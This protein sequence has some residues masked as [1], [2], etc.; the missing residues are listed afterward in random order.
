LE[1]WLGKINSDTVENV[2][3]GVRWIR[4]Y[5]LPAGGGAR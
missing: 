2:S 3:N 5:L 4:P 1:T